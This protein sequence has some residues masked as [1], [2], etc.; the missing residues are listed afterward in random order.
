MS[1][2]TQDFISQQVTREL[3]AR[4]V[5]GSDPETAKSVAGI[6]GHARALHR[7]LD[8]DHLGPGAQLLMPIRPTMAAGHG[9][10]VRSLQS[11]VGMLPPDRPGLSIIV[12]ADRSYRI[13]YEPVDDSVPDGFVK[14]VI[15][16][17]IHEAVVTSTG[18]YDV[19]SLPGLVSP[20]AI[21]YF[22][23]L[24]AALQDYYTHKARESQCLHLQ[25]AWGDERRLVLSNK[26]EKYM[27]R[28]LHDYLFVRLRDAE[29]TV[30]QEQN[31]NETEPVDVRIQWLDSHRISLIEV[32]WL[33]D[34]LSVDGT[35]IKTSYR[36]SRAREGYTQAAHYLKEQRSTLPTYIVRTRLVVFDARRRGV[37]P[38]SQGGFSC[39]A[40]WEYQTREIDYSDVLEN[41]T[42]VEEPV[43]FFLEPS[44]PRAF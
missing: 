14:Y 35:E 27:R 31:V 29:S 6:L 9:L 22:R 38:T 12:M 17:F 30:I 21:P 10:S 26:P 2:E 18:R 19:S 41:D 5:L 8:F 3:Y 24:S 16:P 7:A 23:D 44:V 43:R 40:A 33:G 1:S 34:S 20:F 4:V 36:D 42:G 11:L 28:S 39:Q 37:A 25:Q 15:Q 32:K 13:A